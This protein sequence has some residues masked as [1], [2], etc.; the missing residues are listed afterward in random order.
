[1]CTVAYQSV[2]PLPLGVCRLVYPVYLLVLPVLIIPQAVYLVLVGFIRL[3]YPI[4]YLVSV[5]VLPTLI[6]TKTNVS[7]AAAIASLAM[8]KVADSAPLPTIKTQESFLIII[9]TILAL[10]AVRAT[11][12]TSTIRPAASV[13]QTA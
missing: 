11:S 3:L 1:M 7:Y 6:Y 10:L 8:P 13:Q 2:P 4:A 9:P 5:S 12:L